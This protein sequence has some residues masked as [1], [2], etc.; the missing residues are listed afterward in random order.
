MNQWA[1]S[2][3]IR[4]VEKAVGFLIDIESALSGARSVSELLE[5]TVEQLRR[6]PGTIAAWIYQRDER[7]TL[8]V[9]HSWE[10]PNSGT[11]PIP[12]I[13]LGQFLHQRWIAAHRA[14]ATSSQFVLPFV[15]EGY[16]RQTVTPMLLAGEMIGA[17]AVERRDGEIYPYEMADLGAITT[18]ATMTAQSLQILVLRGRLL[19]QEEQTD[20]DHVR[21]ELG[22]MLHDGIVQDL[23]YMNLKLELLVRQIE[24][25][26]PE[27]AAAAEQVQRQV[28]N[29][30]ND[31]RS[32]ITNLRRRQHPA[33]GITAQL[34][35]IATHIP[36]YIANGVDHDKQGMELAPEIERAVIGIVREA[37]QNIRKHAVASDVRV[38]LQVEDEDLLVTVADDGVGFDSKKPVVR[39]GHFGMEQMRELAEDMGGSLL[40]ESLPDSG[41]RVHARIPLVD[42]QANR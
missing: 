19:E 5:I 10:A 36:E 41:T 17:I 29:S 26:S 6:V 23:A 7:G 34:R 2:S 14:N 4:P 25:L 15:P 9:V 12:E 16:P 33:P 3:Y 27:M 42:T 28:N 39:E 31:L 18:V 35:D 11:S 21:R 40:V 32:T 24:P 22:R 20:V 38:E 1:P 13:E 30:I 8:S 37:L